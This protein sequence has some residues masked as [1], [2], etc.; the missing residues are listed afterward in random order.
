MKQENLIHVWNMDMP[1]FVY[2]STDEVFGDIE[3]GF[4]REEDRLNP[5][6]PYSASKASAELLVKSWSRT[7]GINYIITRTTNNYGERQHSEKLIPMAITRAIANQKIKLH[8]DGT[9]VRNWIYVKDNC[10]AIY[11]VIKKGTFNQIYNIASDEEFSVNQIA[12][13]ILKEFNRSVSSQTVEHIANRAGQDL[14]YALNYEKIKKIGW[15]P[16]HTFA[17]TLP[18]IIKSY[19]NGAISSE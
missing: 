1:L 19:L 15:K 3:N 7:H 16:K 11:N 12:D 2:I 13:M 17:K 5:S 9:Y 10:D 14:R 18:R 4:F 6:N 8:G